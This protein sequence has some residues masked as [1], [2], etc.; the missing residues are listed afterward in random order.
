[1]LTL[2]DGGE[3]ASFAAFTD[4]EPEEDE[5]DQEEAHPGIFLDADHVQKM[6]ADKADWRLA[7]GNGDKL[8]VLTRRRLDE[9]WSS[10]GSGIAELRLEY[11]THQDK[12]LLED[13]AT[14][15]GP[16]ASVKRVEESVNVPIASVGAI[17]TFGGLFGFVVIDEKIQHP[18]ALG[19]TTVAG[20]A[21]FVLALFGR[22]GL[23]RG[24]VQLNRIDLIQKR[25][26]SILNSG[27]LSS[28]GSR[29]AC[30]SPSFSP[31]SRR[32]PAL[33]TRRRRR[34]VRPGRVE[35]KRQ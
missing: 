24:S 4:D 21:A 20:I 9:V 15:L 3:D 30:S 7:V 10:R 25:F 22:Y 14:Y 31:R 23:R 6:L 28:R 8:E 13:A 27:W 17:A 1:M 11:L 34:S 12:R 26:E 18:G 5:P 16:Q 33:R 2:G 35:T 19:I 32:I 29:S